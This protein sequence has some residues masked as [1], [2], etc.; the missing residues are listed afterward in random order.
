MSG[1]VFRI[2]DF[3]LNFHSIYNYT[4]S[5]LISQVFQDLVTH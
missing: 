5:L 4:I 2:T 3:R 1:R